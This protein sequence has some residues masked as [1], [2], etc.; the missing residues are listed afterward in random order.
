MSKE[1]E[2]SS[3]LFYFVLVL[4]SSL[5]ILGPLPFHKIFKSVCVLLQKEPRLFNW[6]CIIYIDQFG[7]NWYFNTNM[8]H[9]YLFVLFNISR[10]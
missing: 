6:Y 5:V 1:P 8:V 7:K 2:N 10:Q 4:Q 9:L 3:R